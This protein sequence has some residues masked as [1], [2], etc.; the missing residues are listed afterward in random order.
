MLSRA[1]YVILMAPGSSIR[2]RPQVVFVGCPWYTIRPKYERIFAKKTFKRRNPLRFVIV[3]RDGNQRAEDLFAEIRR[4]IDSSSVAIF[5]V[6]GGNANASLEF[7]Y[8]QGLEVQS[9][10]FVNVHGKFAA[11]TGP[12]AAIISDLS[13]LRRNP[14]KNEQTLERHLRQFADQHAYTV[15]VA[16]IAAK[17]RLKAGEKA[18]LMSVPRVFADFTRI[19]RADLR[20]LVIAESG[21]GDQVVEK[22]IDIAKR[23]KL[24]KI[25]VGQHG[26]TT[27]RE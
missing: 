23:N 22:V 24:I 9:Y 26:Y 19:R 18:A 8:A 4:Q 7:G 2:V 15:K 6:S 11:D 13:G 1:N 14:Y 20:Q 12:N 27:L 3:G 25:S 21:Y 16:K 5:D 10:V 17:R